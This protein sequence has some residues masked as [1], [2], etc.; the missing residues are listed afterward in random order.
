MLLTNC[1]Q[2]PLSAK[3]EMIVN[4]NIL[5]ERIVCEGI[6]IRWKEVSGF[7]VSHTVIIQEW[8]DSL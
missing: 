5:R 7:E 8:D 6:S 2:A 1:C 3:Q 4:G